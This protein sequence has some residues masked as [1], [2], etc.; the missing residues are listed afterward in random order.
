MSPQ[1][2]PL[3]HLPPDP[4]TKR[5][6]PTGFSSPSSPVNINNPNN[7]LSHL[8]STSQQQ[9]HQHPPGSLSQP[10]TDTPNPNNPN[11]PNSHLNNESPTAAVLQIPR[12]LLLIF[13]MLLL[14]Y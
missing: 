3:S 14:I 4:Q 8:Q 2:P 1:P 5:E 9:L 6:A 7:P 12:V 13:T 11:S 10:E